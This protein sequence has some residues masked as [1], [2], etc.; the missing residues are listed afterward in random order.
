MSAKIFLNVYSIQNDWDSDPIACLEKMKEIGYDGLEFT[1]NI[2]ETLFEKVLA[3]MKELE[4]IAVS[5]HIEFN[6]FVARTDYYFDR[7][8]K[9]GMKYLMIPWLEQSRIPGGENYVQTKGDIVKLAAWCAAKGFTLCYHNHD[10]EFKKINGVCKQ[11]ILLSD[12]PE[13]DT[14]LDVCWC[15][16]GGQNPADYIRRY[17]DRMPTLHLKDFSVEGDI[18]G[19]KLF[20]LLGQNDAAEAAETR[21]ECGFKFQ[22]VGMGHVDF[23]SIFEAADEVGVKWMI[24]EQDTSPDR[25]ALEAAR[26]SFNYISANY[27]R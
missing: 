2:E 3:K 8:R 27:K 7:A 11:D 10:F 22:P 24:V 20:D 26:L 13:L 16:V 4:L 14:Q 25:P 5:T 12:I 19:V 23:P 18:Y 6:D 9:A 17:G 15:V 1:L 21:N